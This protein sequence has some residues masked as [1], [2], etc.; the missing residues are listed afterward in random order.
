[1]RSGGK[2]RDEEKKL[3]KELD[4]AIDTSDIVLKWNPDPKGYFTIKSFHSRK[5]VFV[6]YY[7]SKI[8]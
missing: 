5:K 2:S 6:R 4:E 3:R 7:D 8:A 1:M